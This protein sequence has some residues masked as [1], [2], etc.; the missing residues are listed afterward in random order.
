MGSKIEIVKVL[1][2]INIPDLGQTFPEF[3]ATG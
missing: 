2:A 3:I 1:L